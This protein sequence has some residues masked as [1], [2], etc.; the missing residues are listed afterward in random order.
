MNK[1]L[2]GMDGDVRVL[3]RL[4]N[5]S[6]L[7]WLQSQGTC[8]VRARLIGPRYGEVRKGVGGYP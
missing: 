4:K 5:K 2:G 6:G 1:K 7:S 8:P 3:T